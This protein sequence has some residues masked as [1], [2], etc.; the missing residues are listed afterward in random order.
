MVVVCTGS[1]G[2]TVDDDDNDRDNNKNNSKHQH[3]NKKEKSCDNFLI[4]TPE[5]KLQKYVDSEDLM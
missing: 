2:D 4:F 1:Y 3:K 5:K